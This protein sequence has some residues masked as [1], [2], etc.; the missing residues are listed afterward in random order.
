MSSRMPVSE[1]FP[2]CPRICSGSFWRAIGTTWTVF[3]SYPDISFNITRR[4]ESVDASVGRGQCRAHDLCNSVLQP[5]RTLSPCKSQAAALVSLFLRSSLVWSI[6]IRFRTS[7]SRTRESF[8]PV[9]QS[10]TAQRCTRL[11]CISTK[12]SQPEEDPSVS[13]RLQRLQNNYED[14]GMR[15]TVEGVLV[16]HDHGHPHI[17]MLQIANAFFKL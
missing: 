10:L 14:Y 4:R 17:L 12:E 9:I 3:E 13:A 2:D 16:V 15:R 1:R 5:C 6:G 11:L 7:L 8:L